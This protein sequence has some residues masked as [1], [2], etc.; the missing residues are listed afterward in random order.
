M[1]ITSLC[2]FLSLKNLEKNLPIHFT[3]ATKDSDGSSFYPNW[4]IVML[5]SW[6]S[7]NSDC[8]N[9]NCYK[10]PQRDFY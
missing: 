1:M 9:C 7:T 2:F 3:K 8:K 4:I 5:Y 10:T 6:E